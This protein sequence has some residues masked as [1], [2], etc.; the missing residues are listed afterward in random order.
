MLQGLR[1][2]S[3]HPDHE[4]WRQEEHSLLDHEMYEM[5][6][7]LSG[8]QGRRRME[9]VRTQ[10]AVTTI[11]RGFLR[12]TRSTQIWRCRTSPRAAQ[13]NLLKSPSNSNDMPADAVFGHGAEV[14][15][16]CLK[17]G[18]SSDSVNDSLP[19]TPH[20]LNTARGL[21]ALGTPRLHQRTTANSLHGNPRRI[22]EGVAE[23]CEI[24]T[25]ET[26]GIFGRDLGRVARGKFKELVHVTSVPTNECVYSSRRRARAGHQTGVTSGKQGRRGLGCRTSSLTRSDRESALNSIT[27]SSI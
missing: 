8:L 7:N 11:R 24:H 1:T 5:W 3:L 26:D 19:Q 27:S 2:Y 18:R 6:S 9:M 25:G 12:F 22:N 4:K 17:R 10:L 21:F 14:N 16:P 20:R 23:G 15:R 13:E